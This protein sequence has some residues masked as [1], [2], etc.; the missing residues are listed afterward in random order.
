MFP[1]RE[2]K[3]DV[4]NYIVGDHVEKQEVG[5]F[6]SDH[7]SSGFDSDYISANSSYFGTD[8]SD[9]IAINAFINSGD[10]QQEQG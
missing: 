5:G 1:V 6:D 2:S 10:H 9:H 8:C 7:L 3:T 4:A